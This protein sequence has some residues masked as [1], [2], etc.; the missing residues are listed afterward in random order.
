MRV[1]DV[2]VANRVCGPYELSGAEWAQRDQIDVFISH[3]YERIVLAEPSDN[4]YRTVDGFVREVDNQSF[5]T[6]DGGQGIYEMDYAQCYG[7]GPGPMTRY[8]ILCGII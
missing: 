5:G 8:V 7:A 3:I 2:R 6:A 4:R 1:H